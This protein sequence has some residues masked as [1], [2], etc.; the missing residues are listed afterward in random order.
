MKN[1]ATLLAFATFAVLAITAIR[2]TAQ[3]SKPTSEVFSW[4]GE[5]V[6]FDAKAPTVTVK[7]PVSGDQAH[8]DLARF[9]SG[10]R[11]VLTWSGFDTYADGIAR[12]ARYDATEKSDAPFTFVAEF[13]SYEPQR[14]Y[15]AVRFPVPS[16]SVDGLSPIKPG[17][18]VTATSRH[19]PASN[20]EALVAVNPY[21]ML[22]PIAPLSTN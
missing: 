13:V 5:V 2:V 18:W 21:G 19:R 17:H 7:S 10:D 15:V 11:I 8:A 22:L 3:S 16:A 14:R 12:V 9:K 6:E 20:T 4:S 1:S